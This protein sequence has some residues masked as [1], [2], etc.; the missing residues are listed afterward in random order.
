MSEEASSETRTWKQKALGIGIILA[1]FGVLFG[2]PRLIGTKKPIDPP[3]AVRSATPAPEPASSGAVTSRELTSRELGVLNLVEIR[4]LRK[5][6]EKLRQ[7]LKKP[8]VGHRC[9]SPKGTWKCRCGKT[10]RPK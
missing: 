9:Y 10:W 3:A 4:N 8:T 2:L 1:L 5:E 6:V 7:D